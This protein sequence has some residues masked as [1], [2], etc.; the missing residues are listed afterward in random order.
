MTIIQRGILTCKSATC[1]SLIC[2]L[3]TFH[4][5]I[6][7]GMMMFV[8]VCLKKKNSLEFVRKKITTMRWQFQYNGNDANKSSDFITTTKKIVF[9]PAKVVEMNHILPI[10]IHLTFFFFWFSF[11]IFFIY[12]FLCNFTNFTS[13]YR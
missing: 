6:V 9:L 7:F 12:Y 10:F 11:I 1:S 4:T 5:I 3:L 13:Q 2:I 8:S